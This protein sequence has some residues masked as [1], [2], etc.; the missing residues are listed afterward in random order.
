MS[1]FGDQLYQHGGSPVGFPVAIG[2]QPDLKVWFV[3]P[4]IGSDSYVGNKVNKP[5]ASIAKAYEKART[6]A[7]DIIVLSSDSSHAVDEGGLAITKNRINFVGADWPGRQIQQGAK[8][9]SYSS[10]DDAAYVVKNTGVRNS[11]IGIKFI[12]ESTDAA[13]LTCFQDGGEGTL[14]ER[15]SFVFGV[16]DNLDQTNAYEAILG[17]DSGTFLECIFGNDTLL[18]SA[19]RAVVALDQVTSGQEFKSNILRNCLWQI[20]S[21]STTA[22]FIRVIDTDSVKFTNL[23]DRAIMLCALVSS[24][25][26]AA[27]QD[28]VESVS[29]LVEGNLLFTFP[30]SNATEFCTDVTDQV[31][32]Y[33]PA[34][35]QQAGEVMTPA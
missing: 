35:S 31:Q 26:A 27:I 21:S 10:S 32:T 22:N 28:A 23:F 15:S 25:S 5:L 4:D 3:N 34:T 2:E 19:A 16:A 20:S 8:V 24:A 1:T 9:T 17:T 33:G 11:F 12:Q 30:V 13:A 6:N 14:A 18:T 29:G 7:N